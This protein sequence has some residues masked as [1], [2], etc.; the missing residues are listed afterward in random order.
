M[1]MKT[2]T[3]FRPQ[4]AESVL[5]NVKGF[6]PDGKI[7]EDIYAK[8]TP[9]R[10]TPNI[11]IQGLNEA[12][13]IMPVGSTWRVIVPSA[14]AYGVNGVAGLIPPHSALIFEVELV[15]AIRNQ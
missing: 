15:N 11:F 7:F 12:L 1:I 9:L 13:Q 14:M 4:A 6:L 3:G 8:N 5:I 10:G 2:G